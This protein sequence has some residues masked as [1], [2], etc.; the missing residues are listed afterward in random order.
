MIGCLEGVRGLAPLVRENGNQTIGICTSNA[1][2][3]AAWL[4]DAS[5]ARWKRQ[6]IIAYNFSHVKRTWSKISLLNLDF[7]TSLLNLYFS[8]G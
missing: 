3:V 4:S 8:L 1:W 6:P 7:I 5:Q 2:P